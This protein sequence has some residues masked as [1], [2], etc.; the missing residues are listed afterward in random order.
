MPQKTFFHSF[1]A[2]VSICALLSGCG[3][4]KEAQPD[5]GQQI[6][7]EAMTAYNNGEAS[8]A[9]A[10]LSAALKSSKITDEGKNNIFAALINITLDSGDP[11]KAETLFLDTLKTNPDQLNSSLGRIIQYY[12]R[13]NN[14]EATIE[15]CKK[16]MA[17][18]DSLPEGFAQWLLNKHISAYYSEGDLDTVF[19]MIESAVSEYPDVNHVSLI[20]DLAYRSVSDSKY[21][22]TDTILAQAVKMFPENPE[23]KIITQLVPI[24]SL[25]AQGKTDEA[26]GLLKSAFSQVPDN[27]INSTLNKTLA[28]MGSDKLD[29]LCLWIM[30]THADMQS[31]CYTAARKYLNNSN[32]KPD[33]IAARL[34][35]LEK[36]IANKNNFMSLYSSNFYKTLNVDDENIIVQIH[37]IG[38]RLMKELTDEREIESMRLMLLDSTFMREDY[39]GS[40]A[41]IKQGI[42][43]RDEAWHALALSKLSAHLAMKEDRKEDAIAHFREFMNHSQAIDKPETDPSTGVLHTKEMILGRNAKRI[44]DIYKS[45]P[46]PAEA[47]KAYKEALEYYNT[48]KDTVPAKNANSHKIID[49]ELAALAAASK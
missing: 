8:A 18:K 40:I 26:I 46:K 48:A 7:E 12:E 42:A 21:D 4:D 11:Q 41:I 29:S 5:L 1:L 24:A 45:I 38:Q 3:P 39:A 25:S 34:T 19:S 6:L 2:I 14:N 9:C 47:A 17:I 16:L 44:G 43:S 31:S 15:W 33:Q 20:S 36:L 23:V 30:V 37:D 27:R 22:T 35:A 13:M 49:E 32:N 28:K 10:T